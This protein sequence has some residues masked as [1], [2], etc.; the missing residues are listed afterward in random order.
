MAGCREC[1]VGL[2]VGENWTEGMAKDGNYLCRECVSVKS[3]AH[4][5]ANPKK[6][7]A[8]HKAYRDANPDKHADMGL[9]R[10]F[11]ITLA[12][13]D[14]MLE[15]QEGGCV[16]CGKTPAEQN[17][18]RLCVDHDHKTDEI[19]GLLCDNCNQGL[20][21]FQDNPVLLRSAIN[22]LQMGGYKCLN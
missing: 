22:Y 2:V 17:G 21:R 18:R 8:R 10:N 3:K 6:Q 7:A 4:Y 19:R 1:S 13:Y 5:K 16:I 20:G 14:E 12:D 11:G 15:A 9:R